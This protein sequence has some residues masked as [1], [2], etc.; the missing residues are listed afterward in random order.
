MADPTWQMS[1][2]YLQSLHEVPVAVS[3]AAV[4][5]QA[6]GRWQHMVVARTS[7][8]DLLFTLPGEDYPFRSSV[9]VRWTSGSSAVITRQDNQVLDEKPVDRA[10]LDTEL[11]R[12]LEWLT[13]PA[14][15]C[16][17]CGRLVGISA[18]QFEVFERMHYSCFHYM[19][20]HDPFDP[21][22]EC[23]AGGCPSAS[24]APNQRPEEPRDSLVEEMIDHL[25]G[26]ELGERSADVRITRHGPGTVEA[27][28][29]GDSYLITVRSKPHSS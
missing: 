11:D 2:D 13:S 4:L 3:N 24:I 9:R 20:E 27:T 21:D 10:G 5:A 12:A 19:F 22:E 16:R 1:L 23:T 29:D 15:V 6:R 28:F 17:H 7:M 18:D 25:V 14:L 26:S 8:H